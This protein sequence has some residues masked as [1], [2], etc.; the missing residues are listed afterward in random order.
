M[1]DR[2]FRGSSLSFGSL[3]SVAVLRIAKWLSVRKEF[4][5]VKLNDILYN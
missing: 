2:F 3:L 1:N 5:N 4:A